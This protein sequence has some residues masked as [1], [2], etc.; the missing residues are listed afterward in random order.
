MPS[1]SS[2]RGATRTSGSSRTEVP[3]T[4]MLAI[5]RTRIR[6]SRTTS[7]ASTSSSSARTWCCAGSTARARRSS[8]YGPRDDKISP[9]PKARGRCATTSGTSS[10]CTPTTRSWLRRLTGSTGRRGLASRDTLEDQPD[11]CL[12]PAL[13][14]GRLV[15]AERGRAHRDERFEAEIG[16]HQHERLRGRQVRVEVVAYLPPALPLGEEHDQPLDGGSKRPRLGPAGLC[17]Q[18]D[19]VWMRRQEV[20]LG[21]AGEADAVQGSLAPSREL[22]QRLLEL[23]RTASQHRREQAPLGVEIVEKQLLVHRRTPG[24]L[25]H[26]GAVESATRELLAGCGHNP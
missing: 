23:G 4:T 13:S 18:S 25:I 3:P 21:V 6:P 2:A 14:Q 1:R 5:S 7:A 17:E 15:R 20:E 26:A 24:N 11:R 9:A 10:T 16:D 8:S 22:G 12:L 19:E